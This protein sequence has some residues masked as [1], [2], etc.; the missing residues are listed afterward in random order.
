MSKEAY[1]TI[2][3]AKLLKEHGF[4]WEC[5]RYY[6]DGEYYF[7]TISDNWNDD[8]GLVSIPT[9]QMALAWLREVH[10]KHCDIGYDVDSNWFFQIIDLKE[11]VECHYTEAKCYHVE[12][13]FNTYEE[14]VE[15]ACLWALENLI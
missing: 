12:T 3:T 15:A 4:E 13:E 5:N 2:E 1:V 8:T 11:T 9:H 6:Y 10:N 7:V 14:A